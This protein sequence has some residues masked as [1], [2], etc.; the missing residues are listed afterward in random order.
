MQIPSLKAPIWTAVLLGTTSLMNLACWTRKRLSPFCRPS[1]WL[2]LWVACMGL[3]LTQPASAVG[4]QAR[5]VITALGA[6][7]PAQQAAAPP[8]T[9]VTLG[10]V[11]QLG[12]QPQ[13]A[14]ALQWLQRTTLGGLT[15]T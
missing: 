10:Q 2:S 5:P 15:T 3:R 13:L 1:S 4:Q 6:A 12:M 14:L 7:A 11:A 9:R 8:Q